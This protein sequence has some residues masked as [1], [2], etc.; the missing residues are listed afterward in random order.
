MALVID[1]GESPSLLRHA[2]GD[3]EQL[4]ALLARDL[5]GQPSAAR[6]H[7]LAMRTHELLH[8]R[9]YRHADRPCH[10]RT[11]ASRFARRWAMAAGDIDFAALEER[12]YAGCLDAIAKF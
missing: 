6:L 11:V 10:P 4:V 5:A 12:L 7:R 2:V 9:Q 8:A 3:R 1:H